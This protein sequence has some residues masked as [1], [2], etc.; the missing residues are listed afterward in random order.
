MSCAPIFNLQYLSLIIAGFITACLLSVS[1]S[2]SLPLIPFSTVLT[3]IEPSLKMFIYLFGGIALFYITCLLLKPVRALEF[4]KISGV[5]WIEKK[6]VFGWKVGE[7]AQMPVAQIYALQI[8]SYTNHE[9]TEQ[10]GARRAIREYEVNVV[11]RNGERVNII[12]HKNKKAISSDT[13][14][15]S[16]FLDVPVWDRDQST[17]A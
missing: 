2:S 6:R 15:L 7:S 16:T 1:L 12:N 9:S 3:T 5:F 10:T 8:V 13:E 14:E 17:A 4:D 11:F